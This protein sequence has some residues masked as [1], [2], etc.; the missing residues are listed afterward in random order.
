MCLKRL[1]YHLLDVPKH[2]PQPSPCFL[3][4]DDDFY[5]LFILKQSLKKERRRKTYA[6]HVRG[7]YHDLVVNH[8]EGEGS[9]LQQAPRLW[10]D[11]W[12]ARGLYCEFTTMFGW[13]LS[14]DS[15]NY[16]HGI[17]HRLTV[18]HYGALLVALGIIDGHGMLYGMVVD[19]LACCCP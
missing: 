18:I 15:K 9:S 3:P 16:D 10:G 14:N 6:I 13:P 11:P 4:L 5:P 19:G 17:F 7:D 2:L 12:S 1:L 8:F